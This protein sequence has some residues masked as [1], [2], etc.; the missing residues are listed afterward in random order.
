VRLKLIIAPGFQEDLIKAMDLHRPE[1][2]R[3]SENTPIVEVIWRLGLL[4]ESLDLTRY[5]TLT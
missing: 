5:S 2:Q 3:Q 1:F 4:S